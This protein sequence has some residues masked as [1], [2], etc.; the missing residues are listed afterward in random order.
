MVPG[1]LGIGPAV[2]RAV[3]RA[4][5]VGPGLEWT[6][7]AS[8]LVVHSAQGLIVEIGLLVAGIVI[9]LNTRR[10]QPSAT[11]ERENLSHSK[12]TGGTA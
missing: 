7:T 10:A 5:L 1:H 3:P 4:P 12:M 6:H 8:G 9:Y 2:K 11:A